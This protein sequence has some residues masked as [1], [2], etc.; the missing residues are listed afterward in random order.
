MTSERSEPRG[1]G[2]RPAERL[3]AI[4]ASAGGVEA[5]TRLAADLPGDL[6]AAVVVVLHHPPGYQS[7]LAY[8]LAK[9]GPLP[10]VDASD[11]CVLVP[12]RILVARPG[13]HLVLQDG[14]ARLL[15]A[16]P[17]NR[18]KPAIDPLF[19][20]GAREYGPRL[21]AVVLTGTLNDGS[22]GLIAV[23]LAGG[24]AVIQE[25]HDALFW[26]MPWNAMDAAGADYCVP[27]SEMARLLDA[28]VRQDP[29][30]DWVKPASA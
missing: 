29:V 20:S 27:L 19:Q 25:P 15:D 9:A 7:S 17:V 16:A 18:V 2:E 28:L 3:I 5:L 30:K 1:E 11:G 12:G 10:A 13:R 24:V 23:R 26:D 14:R 6:P 22:A 21:V 4:G 8:L